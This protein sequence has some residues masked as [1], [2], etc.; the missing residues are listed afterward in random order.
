MMRF[1]LAAMLVAAPGIAI[2]DMP[3]G[4]PDVV[5]KAAFLYNFAKFTEWPA[6]RSGAP[7]VVCIVGDDGIAAALVETV[8]GQNIS[9]HTFEVWRPEL[10]S[11]WQ[12][13]SLLF[14]P[15]AETR[16]YAGSLGG[17]KTLPVLTVSDGKGFAHAGGIIEL[18]IEGGRIR[19]LINVDAADRSGLHLSSRLLGLA[20]IVRDGRAQ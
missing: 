12:T 20:K 16:R 9:G 17:V 8:R 13:C 3:Q 4:T 10:S 5:V 14:I 7:I 1:L 6:L 15:D 19:F 11:A 18:Y 2:G